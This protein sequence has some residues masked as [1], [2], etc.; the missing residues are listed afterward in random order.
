M[1]KAALNTKI[2]DKLIK[3]YNNYMTSYFVAWKN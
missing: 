3:V 2:K 1:H